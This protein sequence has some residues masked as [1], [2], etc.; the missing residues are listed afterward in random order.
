MH[1]PPMFAGFPPGFQLPPIIKVMHVGREEL[2]PD[3]KW[4]L[5]ESAS[6]DGP[7]SDWL[8]FRE[9]IG[10]L[11]FYGRGHQPSPTRPTA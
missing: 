11:F 5:G 10:C 8:D 2:I 6:V 4:A 7:P 3:F 9:T 1:V